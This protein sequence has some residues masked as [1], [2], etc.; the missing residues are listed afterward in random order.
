M[1]IPYEIFEKIADRKNYTVII[2]NEEKKLNINAE[3]R[4]FGGV[5]E[6]YKK[7]EYINYNGDNKKKTYWKIDENNEKIYIEFE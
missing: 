5:T 7:K 6:I 3:R 2:D 4:Y 1:P